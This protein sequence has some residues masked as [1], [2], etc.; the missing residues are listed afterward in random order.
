MIR[1][2]GKKTPAKVGETEFDYRKIGIDEQKELM[3]L[4]SQF[5]KD[6]KNVLDSSESIEAFFGW[7]MSIVAYMTDTT[8]D[9][10]KKLPPDIFEPIFDFLIG[11][12]N[13]KKQ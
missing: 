1:Y 10:V 5:N 8:M 13:E 7:K 6:G 12:D 4:F 11:I 2:E 9:E 3:K